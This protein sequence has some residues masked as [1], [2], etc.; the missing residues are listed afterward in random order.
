[1]LGSRAEAREP[2]GWPAATGTLTP[3]DVE[4]SDEAV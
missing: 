1:M 2:V 4:T 3:H